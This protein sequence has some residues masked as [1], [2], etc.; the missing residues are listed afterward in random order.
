MLFSAPLCGVARVWPGLVCGRLLF[1][2][3]VTLSLSRTGALIAAAQAEVQALR[4][5]RASVEGLN[6]MVSRIT[7]VRAGRSGRC[8]GSPR[9]IQ[10]CVSSTGSCDVRGQL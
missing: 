1:A 7:D 5:V 4:T 10:S 6:E 3:K 9:L 2:P 8:W